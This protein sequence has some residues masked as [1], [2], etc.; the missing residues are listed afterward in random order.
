MN[1]STSASDYASTVSANRLTWLV[2]AESL[3]ASAETLAALAAAT[4]LGKDGSIKLPAGRYDHCSRAKGWCRLGRGDAATWGERA[5]GGGYTVRAPGVWT[6][7]SS[8]GFRREE[9]VTWTV[10]AIPVGDQTWLTAC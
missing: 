10:A 1:A 4:R 7:G 9:K 3:G 6:V 8:D 2:L 5:E